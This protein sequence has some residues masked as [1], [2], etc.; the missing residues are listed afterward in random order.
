MVYF[1]QGLFTME[2][3]VFDLD[4]TLLNRQAMI[5]DYTSETLKR[6]SRRE[7]A[8]TVATGRT[9]H[10]AQKVLEG[11][12]FDL[13]QAYKNGVMIWHPEQKRFS[14]ST[15]LA[16]SELERVVQGCFHQGVTPFVFTLDE[17]H[18]STVYYPALQTE[19]DHVLVKSFGIE[20]HV[21][22]HT[23]DQ[24]PSDAVVTHVNSIGPV[25]AINAILHNIGK[26]PQLV[27]YSGLAIEGAQWHW[28]DI[29]HSDASK[30]VAIKTLKELLGFE[31]IIC[32]GD[33]DNDLSM[34]EA[35][36]ESYAPA[37]ANDAIKS[38]ATA[39]VGHHDEDGIARFLRERFSLDQ[40]N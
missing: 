36:D 19:A 3:I 7:I 37:N 24:L 20:G 23:L 10:G 18:Q 33:S 21:W 39:I 6:L 15:T 8:Y 26:E 25:D 9:L 22:T 14:N 5:S 29:H 12:R 34:F 1:S 4:G 13:P 27:A 32:F 31:R 30:G 38:A 35:A 17:N 40:T 16:T 11:H 28:L 2:L